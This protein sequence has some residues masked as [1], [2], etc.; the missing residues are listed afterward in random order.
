MQY[1]LGIDAGGTYTDAVI[2]RDSDSRIL[3]TSKAITTYPNL[4]VGIRNA[5]DKL[6]PEYL[7]KV[8]LVSVSTT[9]ST[10]T[11]LERTGYPVGL[12]LVGDYI[13]PK[14]LPADYCITVKGGHDSDGDEL[15]PLDLTAV[16]QF[17]VSLKKKVSAFAVS[18]YFGT[19]NPEHEL[20][21]KKT[22]LK[23]TGLPVVC[24]HELSQELGAYERAATAVLNAQLIPITY[25]FIHSITAEIKE[26]NL[27]AKVFML[28][29]DGSVTDLKS[30][31]LRP[32]ETIFSGPAASIMGA[33]HLSGLD[34]CAVIDVGGTSTD[35][36]MIKKGV[37]ELCEKGA[38]VGGWQTSVKAIKMESSANGGD[39]HVWFKKYVRIGPKRVMPLCFAA[40]QYPNL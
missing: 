5:I 15:Q 17:A 39:S 30:A 34:T 24:G 32:I 10:N 36:S 6:N 19:R 2:L 25:Q 3:D 28:K 4:M 27:D 13:V 22:I 1:S 21:I 8:K 11:I 14:E 16:E 40:I 33:S 23:L 9:L 29:C 18:S 31:K 12:I 20:K 37:P 7:N 38:V 35:V 26:R